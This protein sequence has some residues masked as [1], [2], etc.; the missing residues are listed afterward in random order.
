MD[1]YAV[2]GNP[3]A[4]SLSPRIHARFGELAG[5]PIEYSAIAA[6]PGDFAQTAREFFAKGGRGANVTLPFKIDAYEMASRRSERAALA[7]AANFLHAKEDGIHADNTDGAGLVADLD[8]NLRVRLEGAQVLLMG[9]GGAARGVIAPLLAARPRQLVIVNRTEI[10]ARELATRF[11]CL[12][13]VIGESLERIPRGHYEVVI[14]ATSTS[15]RGDRLELP[16]HVFEAGGL[17]YD[18]AYGASAEPF[19]EYAR[20]L[21]AL[22]ATDGLGMLVEQAAESFFLWRGKR[23]PTAPV[24]AELRARAAG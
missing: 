21:G 6:P 1:R 16:G 5:D 15:T 19:L 17:A 3:V 13:P 14:N 18:M 11:S 9:A 23:P 24:L 2:F 22:K 8:R 12:G 4:H 7:G 20:S 10:T